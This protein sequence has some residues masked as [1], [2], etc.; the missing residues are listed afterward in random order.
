MV[1]ECTKE[2]LGAR[3]KP[4][5][6]KRKISPTSTTPTGR[7]RKLTSSM[8]DNS[9]LRGRLELTDMEIDDTE[10]DQA[11]NGMQNLT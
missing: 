11:P 9:E 1:P 6:P 7:Q 5:T 8:I 2:S 4:Q 10:P 3:S